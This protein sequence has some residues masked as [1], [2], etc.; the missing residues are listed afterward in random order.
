MATARVF[1]FERELWETLDLVPLTVRRKLDLAE[2]KLSLAG[3][4]GL[5]L[6]DRRALR[7]A[8]VEEDAGAFTAALRAGAERCGA[9]LEPLPLPEGGPPWRGAAV[10]DPVRARLAELGAQLDAPAWGALDDEARYVLFQL[11]GKRRDPE[12]FASAAGEL[13]IGLIPARAGDKAPSS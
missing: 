7:D 1:S 9:R 6:D 5:S 8:E 12:R 2:L 11:A 3:W 10:P 4:K 13:G